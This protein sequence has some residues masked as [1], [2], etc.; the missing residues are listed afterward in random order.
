MKN[1]TIFRNKWIEIAKGFGLALEYHIAGY[2]DERPMLYFCLGWGKFFVSLP[3][4]TGIEECTPSRYGFYWYA[5]ALWLS[6]GKKV[7][8]IHAP[9]SW[10][11]YRT[12]ILLK[13]ESSWENEFKG[14]R[15][16]FYSDVWLDKIWHEEYPYTYIL[17]N[18]KI[19]T[20]KAIVKIEEREWRRKFFMWTHF[21]A[22]I[23]KDIDV[24]FNDELGER[25][26]SWKGGCTGCGYE[27]LEGESALQ[28]LR[29]MEK[30]RK[31]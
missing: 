27:M 1:T 18:G 24:R 28:T 11:W 17:K 3:F 2:F 20:R 19:Q 16:S 23:S 9:W 25:T 31:F 7:K 13:D 26:G 30:E 5:S 6:Y 8:A 29:R 22:K 4:R 15:K 12:S 21:G 10:N 14:N